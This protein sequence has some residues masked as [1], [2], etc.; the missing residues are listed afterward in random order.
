MGRCSC[1]YNK[2][3]HDFSVTN[4]CCQCHFQLA[5]SVWCELKLKGINK[6]DIL[7]F[8][9][10][11]WC[12]TTHRAGVYCLLQCPGAA[13]CSCWVRTP[14]PAYLCPGTAGHKTHR[15]CN[16]TASHKHWD[17]ISEQQPASCSAPMKMI[18]QQQINF[19]E[20]TG[21]M[22]LPF[23]KTEPFITTLPSTPPLH[24]PSLLHCSPGIPPTVP[25]GGHRSPTALIRA[26]ASLAAQPQLKSVVM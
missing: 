20:W 1:K 3:N 12:C 10:F 2:H 14:H 6:L 13:P 21:I 18:P 22:S 17:W 26:L 23:T 5:A 4:V 15:N 24:S 19:F 16:S 9:L 8:Y 11:W 25:R 7:F